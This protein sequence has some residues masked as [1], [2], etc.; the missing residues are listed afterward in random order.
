MCPWMDCEKRKEK[1]M[2]QRMHLKLLTLTLSAG[3]LAGSL[4]LQGLAY[5]TVDVNGFSFEQ[6]TD[7]KSDFKQW[8]EKEWL[9]GDDAA[10]KDVDESAHANTGRVAMTPGRMEEE[11]NFAWYS[12]EKGVPA[13]KIWA[14]GTD[15]EKSAAIFTGKAEAITASNRQ[16]NTYKASNKVTVKGLQ[17]GQKYFYQYTD[18]YMDSGKIDV[19]AGVIVTKEIKTAKTTRSINEKQLTD[20]MQQVK[21]N[22]VWSEIYT[23]AAQKSDAFSIILTG[24]PQ[25]GASDT[26]TGEGARDDSIERDTYNWNRTVQQAYKQ[27]PNAAFLI[28][29]GD[30][31]D[32]NNNSSVDDGTGINEK[33]RESEYAGYLFPAAFRSLPVAATIGNHDRDDSDYTAHFNNPNSEDHLGATEA[34]CDYYFSY[35]KVLFICLNTNNRNQGEHR[36]LMQKAVASHP[37]AKWRIV[38]FHSDIYGSGRWHADADAAS[39]RIIFAPLMDEFDIDVCMTGHD[40]TYSR[41]YQIIDGEVVDYD[42]SSGTVY[43]PEGTMYITTGSASGSKFYNMLS[44]TPYY[45]AE[46]TNAPIPSFLIVDFAEDT[47]CMKPYDY[48]GKPYADTYTIKK[49]SGSQSIDEMILQGEEKLTSLQETMP[50]E[51]NRLR[52]EKEIS[53]FLIMDDMV[54]TEE[55]RYAD[56]ESKG[57]TTESILQLKNALDHLKAVRDSFRTPFDPM[58]ADISNK[59]GTPED[60]LYAYGLVKNT[61]VDGAG[62]DG[63]TLKR[64]LSTL[65]DKTAYA[66]NFTDSYPK[67]LNTVSGKLIGDAKKALDDA[68][69]GLQCSHKWTD[70]EII[71]EATYKKEGSR[72]QTCSNCGEYRTS[73][74]PK[75]NLSKVCMD[76]KSVKVS[77]NCVKVTWNTLEGVDKYKIFRKTGT[78]TFKALAVV[79]E[80]GNG[81]KTRSFPD[82]TVKNGKCYTYVVK[83]YAGSAVS[84]R[85]EGK[86]IV[87]LTRPEIKSVVNTG[88]KTAQITWKQNKKAA[89]YEIAYALSKDFAGGKTV[90]AALAGSRKLSGLTKGKT[91]YVRMRSYAKENGKMYYSAWSTVSKVKISR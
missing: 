67:N 72:A 15:S 44:Y 84:S 27:C 56:L 55:K 50:S 76:V 83:A 89:G 73:K 47:F 39:N 25:I 66:Q 91:Y 29:A 70:G 16:G 26:Y 61:A 5:G 28:S 10:T 24:D 51:E 3:L 82:E 7:V 63:R 35:G 60:R 37:D 11:L 17:P 18:S 9:D 41:S 54:Q 80:T 85:T 64:G 23:Y 4:P 52:E 8:L 49:T 46:R 57:Y 19:K 21:D 71:T 40:H 88:S 13:V 32:K 81:V 87:F 12:R 22:S 6:E 59:Y 68:F 79:E 31:V 20:T 58:V 90:T 78:G 34:G 75:K 42:L 45:I 48:D 86:T 38:T 74:I 1:N 36:A 14:E 33:T 77:G 69:A 62:P 53:E 30:Q 65:V 43:D 2:R